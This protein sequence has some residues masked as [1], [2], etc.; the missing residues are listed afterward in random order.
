MGLRGRQM[1]VPK[2]SEIET[3]GSR[4]PSWLIRTM[5]STAP[6]HTGSALDSCAVLMPLPWWGNIPQMQEEGTTI[7]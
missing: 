5:P 2:E 7:C 3:K 6:T 4:R 1:G